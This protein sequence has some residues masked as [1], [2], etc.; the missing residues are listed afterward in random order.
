MLASPLKP[1]IK[2][3]TSL[4]PGAVGKIAN[5]LVD[6]LIWDNCNKI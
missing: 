1:V 6:V 4:L 2:L 5:T 3:G